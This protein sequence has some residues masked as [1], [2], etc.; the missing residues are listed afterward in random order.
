VS[1]G[2]FEIAD[3]GRGAT[4]RVSNVPVVDTFQFGG[5]VSVPAIVS[6]SMEWDAKGPFVARGKGKAVPATDPAAFLGKL[7]PAFARG[8]FSGRELGFSFNSDPGASSH[9]GYALVGRERNGVFLS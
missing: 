6:F 5:P 9:G 7:A 2:D 4:L 1:S 3:D 8:S